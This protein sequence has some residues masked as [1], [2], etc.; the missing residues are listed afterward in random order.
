M[1][2]SCNVWIEFSSFNQLICFSV[3][4]SQLGTSSPPGCYCWCVCE[5][6]TMAARGRGEVFFWV[7]GEG[8]DNSLLAVLIL[9]DL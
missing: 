8:L 9:Y 4:V 2:I 3:G 1:V 6:C 5:G 7:G